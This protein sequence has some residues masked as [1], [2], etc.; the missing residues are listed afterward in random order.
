MVLGGDGYNFG[1]SQRLSAYLRLEVF[2]SGVLLGLGCG[3][4]GF[5]T[6]LNPQCT[7]FT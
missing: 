6:A 2:I 5:S 1:Y 7:A 3:E 4:P